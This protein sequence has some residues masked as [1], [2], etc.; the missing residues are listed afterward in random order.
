MSNSKETF[1]ADE[2]LC[3]EFLELK[4]LIN[5][6]RGAHPTHDWN[7]LGEWV[8]RLRNLKAA[9]DAGELPG[10][11]RGTRAD[12]SA[13][14]R[15]KDLWAFLTKPDR[16]NDASWDWTRDFCHR[17]AEVR[18]V[19]LADPEKGRATSVVLVAMANKTARVARALLRYERIYRPTPA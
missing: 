5:L 7:S 6:A 14:V 16:R 9:I 4:P 19:T 3:G 10:T 17:W 15:L 18:D 12:K 13:V 1:D 11:L 2:W 8:P